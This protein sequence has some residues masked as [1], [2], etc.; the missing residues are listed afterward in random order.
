MLPP[1]CTTVASEHEVTAIVSGLCCVGITT[2]LTPGFISAAVTGS[3]LELLLE[4]PP[5]LPPQPAIATTAMH[6]AKA[7]TGRVAAAR[8][9]FIVSSGVGLGPNRS[10]VDTNPSC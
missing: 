4:P 7:A 5:P 8:L 6:V 9:I 2:V 10:C 3:K 1:D